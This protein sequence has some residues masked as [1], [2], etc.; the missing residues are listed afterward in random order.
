MATKIKANNINREERLNK[1]IRNNR[2]R[3]YQTLKKEKERADAARKEYREHARRLAAKKAVQARG[4]EKPQEEHKI[5][6]PVSV[7]RETGAVTAS[8]TPRRLGL[9]EIEKR[10][11]QKELEK[12]YGKQEQKFQTVRMQELNR[13]Y[14]PQPQEPGEIRKGLSNRAA[15]AASYRREHETLKR[16]VPLVAAGA[17]AA[18]AG[19]AGAGAASAAKAAA[20]GKLKRASTA[21]SGRMGE[22]AQ[23]VASRTH[24]SVEKLSKP[25]LAEVARRVR[26]DDKSG[27]MK[28]IFKKAIRN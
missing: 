10:A 26:V 28:R 7:D 22:Q 27:V 8:K 3:A 23:R 11:V 9:N 15:L 21:M 4:K 5:V 24:K 16:G 14:R 6:Q 17:L 13:G 18:G 12:R 19:F 1:I 25:K 2:E 20:I